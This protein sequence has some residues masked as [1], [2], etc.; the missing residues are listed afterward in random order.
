MSSSCLTAAYAGIAV[1]D[2]TTKSGTTTILADQ[3]AKNVYSTQLQNIV[4]P[5]DQPDTQ[6]EGSGKIILASS[7]ATA[8]SREKNNCTHLGKEDPH[9][10]GVF[11]YHLI[12]GLDG[13]AA[14][15]DTGVIRIDS[16]RRYIENQM[17]AEKRQR[18]MY[19]VADASGIESIKIGVAQKQFNA[20]IQSLIYDAIKEASIKYP[21]SPLNDIRYLTDAAKKL[22]ELISLNPRNKEISRLQNIIDEALK[23]YFDPTL[24]WLDRNITFA[25][26]KIDEIKPGLYDMELPDLFLSL[27]FSDLQKMDQ[28]K[29]NS[30]IVL[31]TE[32]AANTI[33][34]SEDDQ[35]L[36]LFQGKLRA[37]IHDT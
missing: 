3:N 18:P 16:L 13:E 26:P 10:H 20:K 37:S 24:E 21:N 6:N 35:K 30:L 4:K 22:S 27:S 19:Y 12:N 2:G 29:L 23:A 7:E 8:V 33:F 28:I 1:K 9:T 32:V 17:L 14:D 25:K 31:C 5:S 34:T 36:K 15:R 11:T